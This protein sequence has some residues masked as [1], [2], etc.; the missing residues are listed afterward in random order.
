MRLI[1]LL[2]MACHDKGAGPGGSTDD[3]YE[4]VSDEIT[5]G[6]ILSAWSDGDSL[7]MVGG[8]LGGGPGL[9]LSGDPGA[10][11]VESAIT[12]RALWWIHGDRPGHWVAVGEA[13]RVLR[14][15]DGVRERMDIPTDATLF[16]VWVTGDEIWAAGGHIGSGQN[17]GEIWRWAGTEW[18]AIATDLPGVLFKVWDGWFVGHD[19]AYQWVDGALESRPAAGRLLTVR[20]RDASDIWAVGGLNQAL[21]VQWDGTDWQD[22]NTDGLGQTINGVWTGP[23]QPVWVAGNF[24]VTS[25]WDGTAWNSPEMP[26]TTDHLHAVWRHDGSIWWVGGDL[27]NV[28]D[29]HGIIIRYGPGNFTQDIDNCE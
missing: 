2:L 29:N 10:L 21:V 23:E 20:G 17:D 5:G 26:L 9:M 28:G 16:G 13:G 4:V 15:T 3:H 25:H 7:R 22:I 1:L 18:T 6:V 19:V 11:C 12:D 27:F 24:G 8:D 14:S